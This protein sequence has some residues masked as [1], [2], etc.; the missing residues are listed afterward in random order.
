MSL[1]LTLH[2]TYKPL[3]LIAENILSPL[4]TVFY[5]PGKNKIIAMICVPEVYKACWQT[6]Y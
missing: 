5:F 3:S 1:T 6:L 2:Q 4:L